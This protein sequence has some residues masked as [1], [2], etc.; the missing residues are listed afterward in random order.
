MSEEDEQRP[1]SVGTHWV[2]PCGHR[3]T[4][5][6]GLSPEVAAAEL[7]R[8]QSACELEA[9]APLHGGI[10]P[11]PGTWLIPGEIGP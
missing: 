2:L 5:P 6:W 7:L 11:S 4:L 9:G 1:E 10:R 3:W 8:H